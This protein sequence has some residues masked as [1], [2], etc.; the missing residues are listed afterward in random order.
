VDYWDRLGW[1]DPY[2]SAEASARQS[3]Y[4]KAREQKTRWTPQF[5]VDGEIVPNRD[6]RGI[7]ECVKRAHEGESPVAVEATATIDGGKIAVAVRLRDVT[8]TWDPKATLTVTSVLVRRTVVTDVS[9][10]ENTGKTLTEHFVALAQ[11]QPAKIADALSEKGVAASFDAPDGV[12][13]KELSVAVIVENPG[14]MRIVQCASV[15]VREPE[16][17]PDG[18]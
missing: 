17:A 6:A 10:G 16:P 15:P 7:P 18:R 1:K 14:G 3:R 2:G 13:T 12:D 11:S 5:V 8:G 9:K 4:A